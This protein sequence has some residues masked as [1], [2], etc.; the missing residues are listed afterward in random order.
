MRPPLTYYGGKQRL[1]KFILPK[2]PPHTLYVE[3]FLG[4][5]AIFWNKEPSKGEVLNDVNGEIINFYQVAKTKF[6]LLN[7]EIQNTLHSRMLHRKAYLIHEFPELFSDIKRAWAVWVLCNMGFSGIMSGSFGYDVNE[8]KNRTQFKKRSFI[9]Q[10]ADRLEGVCIEQRDALDVIVSRDR[11]TTF[12]YCDP[13]YYNSNMGHYGGYTE[14]DFENLLKL[15]ST[16]KGKF[17]LSSYPSELL[18]H[19]TMKHTWH[20][21][22]VTKTI[23]VNK[24]GHGKQKT[25]VLTANYPISLNP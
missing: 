15:L 1:V 24:G 4:G 8:G 5:G 3:P 2:I 22:S 14:Q 12:F 9:K 18:A 17:L 11:P 19:Y 7:A 6:K 10:L 21:T 25:E 23:S 16:I 20:T 13:P